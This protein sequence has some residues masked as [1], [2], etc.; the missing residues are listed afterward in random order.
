MNFILVDGLLCIT[1]Q[2][3]CNKETETTQIGS[4]GSSRTSTAITGQSITGEM[5]LFRQGELPDLFARNGMPDTVE[6]EWYEE[7]NDTFYTMADVMFT[8][9]K[10]LPNSYDKTEAAYVEYIANDISVES[11][12]KGINNIDLKQ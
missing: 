10:S 12:S 9:F 11:E 6:V 7:M 2:F 8:S 4:A 1:T 3:V 5:L